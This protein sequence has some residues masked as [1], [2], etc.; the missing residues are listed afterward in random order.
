MENNNN[1][2]NYKDIYLKFSSVLSGCRTLYDALYFAQFYIK[3]NPECKTL[4]NNMIHGKHYEKITDFRTMANIL[5][6]LNNFQTRNEI[7]TYINTSINKDNLDYSQLNSLLR[8]GKNKTYIKQNNNDIN[9]LNI[10]SENINKNLINLI[11]KKSNNDSEDTDNSDIY[12][13][14]E[15]IEKFE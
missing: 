2:N 9:D 15:I 8:L 14:I 10:L 5:K 12:N 1:N 4:I 13:N 6:M 3:T 11:D 7:D